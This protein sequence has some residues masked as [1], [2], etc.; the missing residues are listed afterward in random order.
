MVLSGM[1]YHEMGLLWAL[2][3]VAANAGI[4]LLLAFSINNLLPHRRYPVQQSVAPTEVQ[5]A[6]L[7]NIEQT[8]IAWALAQMDGVIDIG[9]DDLAR[10]YALALDH[11]QR[12]SAEKSA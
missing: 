12:R 5:P 10:I 1:S 9:E 7:I 6:P 4:A 2:Y 3:I 11:S 8:D